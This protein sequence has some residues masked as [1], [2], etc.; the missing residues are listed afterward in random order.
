MA[1]GWIKL[2]RQL[3]DNPLWREEKFSRGQ[4]WVDL[5]MLTNYEDSYFYKRG[6]KIAVKSGQCA[7]SE[8]GL[9]KRWQWSRGK[10]KRFLKD[11]ENEHQISIKKDNVTQLVTLLKYDEYQKKEHQVIHQTDTRRTP[12]GHLKEVKEVKEVK[13]HTAPDQSDE[14]YKSKKGRVLSNSKLSHFNS[15]WEA[16]DY[17][18]GRAEAADAFLNVYSEADV[19]KIIVGAKAEAAK[20]KDAVAKGLTPKM[21]QGWL[22]GRRWE[23]ETFSQATQDC[24]RCD[25]RRNGYCEEDKPNCENFKQVS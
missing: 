1:G 3:Q 5:I 11:L 4:A 8:L 21:A 22:S 19:E 13:K 16:F 6:V 25:Y 2:H 10:V 14:V 18:K 12:D 23:D 9:S 24:S 7:W 17:K 15:F 20:R